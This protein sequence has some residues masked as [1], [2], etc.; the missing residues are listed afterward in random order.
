[1]TRFETVL[2]IENTRSFEMK[3][4]GGIFSGGICVQYNGLGG[5]TTVS[6]EG[7]ETITTKSV[8]AWLKRGNKRWYRKYAFAS[9]EQLK[10]IH[11]LMEDDEVLALGDSVIVELGSYVKD[12]KKT[13]TVMSKSG[14]S[15][16]SVN[17]VWRGGNIMSRKETKFL[18]FNLRRR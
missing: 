13:V 5:F 15:E 6:F 11:T 9:A 16:A 18:V 7:R 17:T 10:A 14:I 8:L 1:M 4:L 12:R 2:S 3:R